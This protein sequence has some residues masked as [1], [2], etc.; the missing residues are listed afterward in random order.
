LGQ[1]GQLLR[2]MSTVACGATGWNAAVTVPIES[3]SYLGDPWLRTLVGVI[4]VIA[5]LGAL[6]ICSF[7]FAPVACALLVVAVLWPVQTWLQSR[8]PTR[9]LAISPSVVLFAVFFWTFL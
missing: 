1:L 2:A 4:A 7:V 9:A 5:A 6:Y 8:L 3:R